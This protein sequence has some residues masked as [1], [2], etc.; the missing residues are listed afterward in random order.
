MKT[1]FTYPNNITTDYISTEYLG[2]TTSGFYKRA[3]DLK[4]GNYKAWS[5]TAP[6]EDINLTIQAMSKY[7]NAFLETWNENTIYKFWE[8]P[9]YECKL[10]LVNSGPLSQAAPNP[11]T[12]FSQPITFTFAQPHEFLDGEN[13]VPSVFDGDLTAINGMDV[14]VKKISATELQLSTNSGL[15]EL[16]EY[17]QVDTDT[18]T[19]STVADPVVFT[20]NGY[21]IT[22]HVTMD[23]F[24]GYLSIYNTGSQSQ[25]SIANWYVQPIDANTFNLSWDQAGTSLLGI[26][27]QETDNLNPI[28]IKATNNIS[29]ARSSFFDSSK[30]TI[31]L[32]SSTPLPDGALMEY[33]F[34]SPNATSAD[35]MPIR[36]LHYEPWGTTT[37]PTP[38]TGGPSTIYEI[39]AMSPD[40]N[41]YAY[42]SDDSSDNY[43]GIKE[44]TGQQWVDKVDN[45][46]WT[47]STWNDQ[48]YFNIGLGAG[49]TT[50]SWPFDNL[51]SEGKVLWKNYVSSANQGSI[52]RAKCFD[53]DYYGWSTNLDGDTDNSSHNANYPNPADLPSGSTYPRNADGI[54]TDDIKFIA[55]EGQYGFLLDTDA[56]DP[57][58][59]APT[60]ATGRIFVYGP[61]VGGTTYYGGDPIVRGVMT[62]DYTAYPELDVAD[63]KYGE[64]FHASRVMNNSVSTANANVMIVTPSQYPT[65]PNTVTSWGKV[66]PYNIDYTRS[67]SGTTAEIGTALTPIELNVGTQKV[68]KYG[69][70]ALSA[71]GKT[72]VVRGDAWSDYVNPHPNPLRTGGIHVYKFANNTWTLDSEDYTWDDSGSIPYL[73]TG[74]YW[75]Q[76]N[77]SKIQL[78]DDGLIINVFRGDGRPPYLPNGGGSDIVQMQQNSGGGSWFELYNRVTVRACWQGPNAGVPATDRIW[79]IGRPTAAYYPFGSSGSFLV[80]PQSFIIPALEFSD[81]SSSGFGS[82]PTSQIKSYHE[83]TADLIADAASPYTNLFLKATG[84]SSGTEY[85]YGIFT[86]PA[87]RD[88]HLL[89]FGFFIPAQQNGTTFTLNTYNTSLGYPLP[90]TNIP[91]NTSATVG[92]GTVKM[93][94]SAPSTPATTYD[95]ST[96]GTL[97][98]TSVPNAWEIA[99]ANTGDKTVYNGE[100]T[101]RITQT[102]PY[103]INIYRYLPGNLTYKNRTGAST[104]ANA[105]DISNSVWVPG[106]TSTSGGNS[107]VLDELTISQDSNGYITDVTYDSSVRYASADEFMLTFD[108][109]PDTYTPPAPTLAEQEDE[110]DTEDEWADYGYAGGRKEWPF[111]VTPS[112]ADI[113][114]NAPT[115]ANMSQSGIKYTRSVGHTD[116]RLDVAYPPMT[117][118]EFQKFHAIAQAA[119]GQAMPFFFKLRDKDGGPILWR[120]FEDTSVSTNS[121]R[122]KNAVASGDRLA[123]VEGFAANES[124]AFIQGEVFLDGNNDNGYVHT[125]LNTV[126][127]NVYGEAKIRTPW[128]FRTPVSPGDGCYKEPA[129]IVV[130]LA[131]DNFE[132]KVDTA[133]YYYMSVSFDLD[134]WK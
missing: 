117:H 123:L 33:N 16:L 81:M 128:P 110:W 26:S 54:S 36:P 106:A 91:P 133:G 11:N 53:L 22:G 87:C 73:T 52:W 20:S 92:Q 12:A 15:T 129:H 45:A 29:S 31:D 65:N 8:Q 125:V 62:P 74:Q 25:S 94:R 70:S 80:R 108:T 83:N 96:T 95:P 23:N 118:E 35:H 124:N 37:P 32:G 103:N 131:N 47:A 71:D 126:D 75:G 78:S 122:F 69:S 48:D 57:D 5:T 44:W 90:S 68:L 85:E 64:D 114:Y 63:L 120:K 119:Q 99:S 18:I 24:D 59:S 34:P 112:K 43:G 40:G 79:T 2:D 97:T 61:S 130:T 121:P 109:L 127:A 58:N 14:Y 76:Y 7:H 60:S 38:S 88:V 6:T 9:L 111:H 50:S 30:V 100:I 86:Q 19:S 66:Y 116:W 49:R 41:R 67:V 3:N 115:I 1:I 104:Y 13:V 105:A 101:M 28:Q 82:I 98:E 113:V 17:W 134:D 56:P 51:G 72:F 4:L 132:Y 102:N 21:N 77:Y 89:R 93:G 10:E 42:K 55:T 84:V 39:V 107:N 27:T 46:K